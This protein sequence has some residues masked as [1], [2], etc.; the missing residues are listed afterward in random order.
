MQA[1][2][3]SVVRLGVPWWHLAA[4]CEQ[5][6]LRG[7]LPRRF[8]REEAEWGRAARVVTL[9]ALPEDDWRH[10]FGEG[11]LPNGVDRG[12]DHGGH[13]EACAQ[14]VLLVHQ[15]VRAEGTAKSRRGAIAN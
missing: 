5:R 4:L 12:E 14:R 6:H 2:E 15:D 11:C 8:V 10:V 3:R 9:A 13:H 1:D 7:V